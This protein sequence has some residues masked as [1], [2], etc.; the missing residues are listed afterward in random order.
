MI[1]DSLL[2]GMNIKITGNQLLMVLE[3]SIQFSNSS[4]LVIYKVGYKKLCANNAI[5]HIQAETS[6]FISNIFYSILKMKSLA[7]LNILTIR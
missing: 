3:L 2:E 6:G 7:Y 5:R 1:T 4:R